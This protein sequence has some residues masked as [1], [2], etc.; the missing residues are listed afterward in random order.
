MPPYWSIRRASR[1]WR[2]RYATSRRRKRCEA[3]CRAGA[4]N[5]HAISHGTRRSR[6]PG[7]S[8]GN[9]WAEGR[10]GRSAIFVV[11]RDFQGTQEAVVLGG[12]F[13][14]AGGF[15]IALRLLAHLKFL[16]LVLGP[17]FTAI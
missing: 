16:F 3:N 9:C 8:T 5:G 2:R 11:Y 17:F 15:E 1:S 6:K 7:T 13:D 4:W 10:R 14:F 12:E